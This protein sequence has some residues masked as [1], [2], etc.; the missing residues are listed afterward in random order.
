MAQT[1]VGEAYVEV[2]SRLSKDFASKLREDLQSRLMPVGRD[3]GRELGAGIGETAGR[4]FGD[5]FGDNVSARIGESARDVESKISTHFGK[6]LGSVRSLGEG[7][8]GL[9]VNVA[10]SIGSMSLAAGAM[11]SAAGA[12]AS[13][14]AALAPAAGIVAALPGALALGAAGVSTLKVALS[15][16]G[17]AFAAALSGDYEKFMEEATNISGVAGEV[18]YELF[19]MSGAFKFVKESVQDAL[20]APLVGEMESLR[21]VLDAVREGMTGVSGEFGK[22]ALQLLEFVRSSESLWAIRSIFQSL[23][24]SVRAFRPALDPLLAGFRDLSVVGSGWLSTLVPGIAQAAEKFGLFLSHASASGQALDWMNTALAVFKQLGQIAGDVGGI[25]KAVFGALE[26][27]GS[28]A[29]GII[30]QLTS[31]MRTFLESAKGQDALVRIFSALQQIG[32]ALTPVLEALIGA[33]AV[34]A[35]AI[36][37]VAEAL[38]PVLAAAITAIAPAVAQLAMGLAEVF[39]HLMPLV[40]IIG[41]FAQILATV[42]VQALNVIAPVIPTVAQAILALFEALAPLIPAVAELAALLVNE[43]ARIIIEMAPYLPD[44][45]RA[46]IELTFAITPLIRPIADLVIKL[47]PLLPIVTDVIRLF[48]E[49]AKQVLPPLVDAIEWLGGVTE[50]IV[51]KINQLWDDFYSHV[52]SAVDKIDDAISWF[53]ELPG[54]FS[55]WFGRA[56]DGAVNAFNTVVSTA[57]D[58]PATIANAISNIGNNLRTIGWNAIIGLWN[59]I[60]DAWNRFVDWWN[61]AVDSIVDAAKRILGIASPSKVFHEIGRNVGEGL[62][63]GVKATAGL[64]EKAVTGLADTA[65]N[66]WDAPVLTPVAVSGTAS[67]A[68]PSVSTRT[69]GSR[70]ATADQGPGRVYNV[71]VNAAPTV[72]T[73]RQLVN[74]LSYA[75]TLY[76]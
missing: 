21:P 41:Q 4:S 75:D 26:Q 59:G 72:P 48:A 2:H 60:V 49:L 39:R 64:V 66:A 56:K 22:G 43:L 7:F 46:F 18:A 34:L 36:A 11:A 24:D 20:F 31:N 70:D 44:M 54:K 47:T 42:L 55:E 16:V 69:T 74:A 63:L 76:M 23:E 27:T 19:Q 33:V 14:G 40:P 65:V 30:G 6:A 10:S 45:V 12:A 52:R 32:A 37:Q 53:G 58:L 35:P 25:I 51:A 9:S 73:E 8:A 1:K 29:L 28:S 15:G 50:K 13:L 5:S 17:D 67:P 71:T 57:R 3:M 68:T 62:A 38:G 61:R